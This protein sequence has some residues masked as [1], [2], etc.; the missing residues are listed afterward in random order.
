MDDFSPKRVSTDW[1][2]VCFADEIND[3]FSLGNACKLF[4]S[5]SLEFFFLY[6]NQAPFYHVYDIFG[7]NISL[8]VKKPW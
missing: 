7:R 2:K 1:I 5:T 8:N 6:F 4:S 3:I